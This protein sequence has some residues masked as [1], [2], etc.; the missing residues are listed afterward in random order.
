MM[1]TPERV[2]DETNTVKRVPAIPE[3]ETGDT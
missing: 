1:D 2:T 3:R